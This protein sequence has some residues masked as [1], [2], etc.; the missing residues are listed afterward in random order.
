[1]RGQRVQGI[2]VAEAV[3]PRNAARPRRH[4]RIGMN[5]AFC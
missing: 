2:M 3:V 5:I 1:M 4:D